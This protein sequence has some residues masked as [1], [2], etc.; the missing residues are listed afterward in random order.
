L[1]CNAILQRGFTAL[2]A[3]NEIS[4]VYGDACVH[5]TLSQIDEMVIEGSKLISNM[6]VQALPRSKC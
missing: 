3:M 4:L 6:E 2:Q 1:P 5:Q